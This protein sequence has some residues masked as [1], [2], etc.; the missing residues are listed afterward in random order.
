MNAAKTAIAKLRNNAKIK[1]LSGTQ[2]NAIWEGARRKALTDNPD[3]YKLFQN[4]KGEFLVD[5][6]GDLIPSENR[7][8]VLWNA[9]VAAIEA[10]AQVGINQAV[11]EGEEE[12]DEDE[13]DIYDIE[14]VD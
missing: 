14:R 5:G 8:P 10:Y 9:W 2:Q 4:E 6:K 7:D 12:E 1:G 13:E 3:F 11:P